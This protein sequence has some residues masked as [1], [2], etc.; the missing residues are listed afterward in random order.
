MRNKLKTTPPERRVV[1]LDE[2]AEILRISRDPH[3]KRRNEKK[4]RPSVL[5]AGCL[6]QPQRL[7]ECSPAM[8]LR[9]A[10]DSAAAIRKLDAASLAWPS[11]QRASRT[12]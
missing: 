8:P 10:S 2:A 12:R 9:E 4:S 11:G 6:C 1:T 3:M 5:V 7:S